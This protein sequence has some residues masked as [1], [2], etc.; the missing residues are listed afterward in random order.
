MMATRV[1]GRP[2]GMAPT[3]RIGEVCSVAIHVL[4]PATKRYTADN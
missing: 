3:T 4:Q 1:P 2:Q